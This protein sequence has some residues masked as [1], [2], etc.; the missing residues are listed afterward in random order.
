MPTP[1]GGTAASSWDAPVPQPGPGNE[2]SAGRPHRSQVEGDRQ[3]NHLPLPAAR[4][5][6]N[7]AQDTVGL[8]T[9]IAEVR[10][11]RRGSLLGAV[12]G[13]TAASLS[14][15]Q[16]CSDGFPHRGIPARTERPQ[17]SAGQLSR[18][19]LTRRGVALPRQRLCSH[20]PLPRKGLREGSVAAHQRRRGGVGV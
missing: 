1:W 4:P 13:R 17:L 7:S 18:E 3:S 9:L 2:L 12:S 14:E 19:R 16:G 11:D 6:S 8:P 10:L 5:F 15:V 20:A